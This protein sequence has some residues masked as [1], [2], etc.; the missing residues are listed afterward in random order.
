ME[1]AVYMVKDGQVV[2]APAPEQ[3]YGALTINWQGGKPC[4]GKIEESFK[5]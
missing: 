5:I 2:K 3:G 4:H 1:N